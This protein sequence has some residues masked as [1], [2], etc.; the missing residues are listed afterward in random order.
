MD[1]IGTPFFT[2]D[3]DED[4]DEQEEGYHENIMNN[5]KKETRSQFNKD[6]TT[7]MELINFNFQSW[8]FIYIH[9]PNKQ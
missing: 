8:H 3:A 6:Y 2:E 9:V 5:M 4:E 1:V 7:N